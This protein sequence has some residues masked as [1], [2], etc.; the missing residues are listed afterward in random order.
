MVKLAID[1]NILFRFFKRGSRVREISKF[2]ELYAPSYA[3]YELYEKMDKIV[4]TLRISEED[5]YKI[6]F[7]L[8]DIINFVSETH[9]IDKLRDAYEIAKEF[10]EDDTPFIALA[11]KLGIPIW[12]NDKKMIIHGLKSGKY[13]AL[14]TKAVED[15]IV[16]ESLER[17]KEDLRKR[18]L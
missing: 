12:T 7:S 6:Y 3:L 5:Y 10:D 4:K 17:V 8:G 14:D 13:L 9:Y 16:G 11:L 1:T 2:V 15:L 18:V